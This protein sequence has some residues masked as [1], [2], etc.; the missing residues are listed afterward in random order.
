MQ[1]QVEN[2]PLRVDV[3]TLYRY[4]LVEE[5]RAVAPMKSLHLLE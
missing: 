2:P 1:R 3:P 4:I 5:M